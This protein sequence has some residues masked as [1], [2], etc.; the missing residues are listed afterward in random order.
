MSLEVSSGVVAS[1]KWWCT[2]KVGSLRVTGTKYIQRYP[3]K[4]WWRM[5]T[6]VEK[7]VDS[8]RNFQEACGVCSDIHVAKDSYAEAF[9]S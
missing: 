4:S 8:R 7:N 6:R 1:V 2:G 3:I 9:T 5:P